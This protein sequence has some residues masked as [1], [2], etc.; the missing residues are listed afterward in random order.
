MSGESMSHPINIGT[1]GWAIPAAQ[2]EHFPVV[3]SQ[4]ERYAFRLWAVEIN[5][6]FYRSHRPA[7]LARWAAC[8]P[9]KF[10]F[11]VKVPK[12]ITHE[13]R[14][15]DAT[16]LFERFLSEVSGLGERLGPLLVQLPPSLAFDAPVATAFFEA[17]RRRFSGPVVCEPRHAS[18][19]ADDV[20]ARFAD[21]EIARAAA[22]PAPGP[23]AAE[24]GWWPGL[25]YVRLHGSPR[26]YFSAYDDDFIETL[27]RRLSA[28]AEQAPTWC[29]FD[30]T[31]HGHAM[32]HA[33]ALQELL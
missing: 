20:A 6:T 17:L 31:A 27:A 5:S 9:E 4:L 18:W 7:T 21:L 15:V 8:V 19:F 30:N 3:G 13:Q 32:A 23:A 28:Y 25:V 29:I 26:I 11:A 33:L 12:Q 16:D 2:R 10:R 24:P 22:D 1:T 14:L